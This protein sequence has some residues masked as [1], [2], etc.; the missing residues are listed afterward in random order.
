VSDPIITQVGWT[1][2][3]WVGVASVLILLGGRLYSKAAYD[4]WGENNVDKRVFWGGFLSACGFCWFLL[5]PL[6]IFGSIK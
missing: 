2:L 4:A 3:Q 1:L 6:A 5:G